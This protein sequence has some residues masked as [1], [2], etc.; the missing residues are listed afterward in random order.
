M[1]VLTNTQA[2]THYTC[3]AFPQIPQVHAQTHK[4]PDTRENLH[5]ART[6][7][8]AVTFGVHWSPRDYTLNAACYLQLLC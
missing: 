1:P 2:C 3:P 4:H 6:S 7:A 8:G 5:R